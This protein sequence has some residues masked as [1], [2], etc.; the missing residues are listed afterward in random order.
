MAQARYIPVTIASG[1]SV[2]DTFVLAPG[3][4]I[5]ALETPATWTAADLAVQISRDGGTNF[6]NIFDN[7]GA[8]NA[9]AV[10]KVVTAANELHFLGLISAAGGAMIFTVLGPLTFRLQSQ[11]AGALTTVNQGAARIC[12]VLAVKF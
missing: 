3:E 11:T 7:A 8:A 6:L 5:I 1:A 10:A 2:S 12:Q 4:L 9:N